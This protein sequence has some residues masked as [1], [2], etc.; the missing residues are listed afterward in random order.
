MQETRG[1]TF[2]DG[3]AELLPPISGCFLEEVKRGDIVCIEEHNGRVVEDGRK[4]GPWRSGGRVRFRSKKVG[5]APISPEQ[6][7]DIIG[8]IVDGGRGG[9]Q[10]L[11]RIAVGG[12]Y[13]IQSA[14]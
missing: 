2:D 14:L 10:P 7:S 13:G 5:S 4:G 1:H 8:K 3:W 11:L 9:W 12:W 6:S